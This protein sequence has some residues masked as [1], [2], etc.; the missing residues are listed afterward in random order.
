LAMSQE[1]LDVVRQAFEAYTSRGGEAARQFLHPEVVWN[2]ADEAPAHGL[3]EVVGYMDRWEGEWDELRTS[4]EE[5][6]DAGERVFVTVHF[7]GRGKASGIEV[8]AR[9]YEVF[10]V[11]DGKI[12]AM[13]E[14]SERS[15]A[16]Q[17]AGLRE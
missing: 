3:D 8:D 7:W 16:L 5:F 17:A 13:D 12:I 2:A 6:I 10:I 11:R 4:A 9:L 1:N 14:F 15:R